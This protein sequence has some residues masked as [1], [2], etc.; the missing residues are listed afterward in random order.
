MVHLNEKQKRTHPTKTFSESP[1]DTLWWTNS[2]QLNMAIEIVDFPIK[3]MMDLSS[4]QT[5]SSPEGKP[6]KTAV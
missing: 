1:M 5:V 6:Q 3:K 2:S 4:S